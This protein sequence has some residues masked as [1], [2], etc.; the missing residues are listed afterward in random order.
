LFLGKGGVGKTTCAATVALRLAAAVPARRVLLL[1][2]DP[3]PSLG[4]VF[5]IP[6]GDATRSIPNGPTNLRVRELDAAAV[7]AA[8]RTSI[9]S[10]L[11]EL[12]A[13]LGADAGGR[14]VREVMDLAPPGIDELLGL[15]EMLAISD[16]DTVIVD[17]APTGHALRLLEMPDVT[18]EWIQALMRVL[19]KY[20]RVARPGSLAAD[21]VALSRSIRGL[22]H[23]LQDPGETRVIVVTRASEVP[24]LE[25][26]RLLRR[27]RQMN[28]QTA[29][30]IVNALT[31]TPGGCP[32][33][34]MVAA[35]ERAARSAL[36]RTCRRRDCAI[37]L[38]PLAAPPPRGVASLDRWA[39]R[40]IAQRSNTR[41]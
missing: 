25:T 24:R 1:S 30:V 8:R 6:L 36:A 11:T 15:V 2:T 37:I 27:L 28:L 33:C 9:E 14:G 17:A 41:T 35:G 19:L 3:A 7:L 40:W 39:S 29:A 22:Q 12:V 20:R 18:R 23:R 10:S 4:D 21:L 26:E 34:R 32:R 13:S 31:M 5:G 38:T 16:F